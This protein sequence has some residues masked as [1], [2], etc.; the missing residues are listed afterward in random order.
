MAQAPTIKKQDVELIRL[1]RDTERRR[2]IDPIEEAEAFNRLLAT[3]FTQKALAAEIRRSPQYIYGRR[4]LYRAPKA[5]HRRIDV[6]G[7]SLAE[8]LARAFVKDRE[9]YTS[10]RLIWLC[11]FAAPKD[12]NGKITLR[13]DRMQLVREIC[14]RYSDMQRRDRAMRRIVKMMNGNATR[15]EEPPA[16]RNRNSTEEE[17]ESPL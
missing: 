7:V 16:A 9:P 14:N 2:S 17:G 3:G 10:E 12:R 13:E 8:T 1:L 15:Q 4:V 6:F 11:K 5:L